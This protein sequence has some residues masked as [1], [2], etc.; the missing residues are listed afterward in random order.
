MKIKSY[1]NYIN[2]KNFKIFESEEQYREVDLQQLWNDM[3]TNYYSKLFDKPVFNDAYFHSFLRKLLLEKDV[4]IQR[5]ISRIDG[6]VHYGN[7][8]KVEEVNFYDYTLQKVITVKFYKKQ[9]LPLKRARTEHII[10]RID[11]EINKNKTS[12]IVKIYNSEPLEIEKKIQE[13]KTIDKYN[14]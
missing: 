4:E 14:L 6:E 2:D 1:D 8:G 13:L 5:G 12:Q 11:N 9:D 3:F 10:A 7:S